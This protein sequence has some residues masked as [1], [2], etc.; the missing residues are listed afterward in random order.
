MVISPSEL[1]LVV[2]PFAFQ[3]QAI[4][5]EPVSFVSLLFPKVNPSLSKDVILL[6]L[7]TSALLLFELNILFVP[8]EESVKLWFS[9]KGPLSLIQ[10]KSG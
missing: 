3:H 5:V 1:L 4:Y 6:V 7:V 8:L 10:T 2:P 9:A